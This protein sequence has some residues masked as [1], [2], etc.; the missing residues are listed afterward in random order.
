MAFPG[1]QFYKEICVATTGSDFTELNIRQI[2][3]T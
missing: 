3:M 2:K 1:D